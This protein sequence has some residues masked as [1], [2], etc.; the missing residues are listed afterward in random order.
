MSRFR[1]LTGDAI[2][3]LRELPDESVHCVVT[4]PPYWGLRDY[5]AEGQIGLE[6]HPSDWAERLVQVFREVRRVLR[7]D[8]TAWINLGDSY[9]QGGRGALGDSSTL[10][11]GHAH[12]QDES[13]AALT[14]RGEGARRPPRGLKPKDLIGQPWMFAFAAR[15][16]G[17][18][19]RADIV[20]SKSNPLPESIRDRPTKAHEYVFLLSKSAR[21]FY[22]LEAIR[23]PY[24]PAS[25]DRRRYIDRGGHTGDRRG[26]H[27]PGRTPAEREGKFYEANPAGRNRRS[28]WEISTQPFPEAHFAT[29]PEDLVEP[30]VM[31]GSSEAGCCSECGAPLVRVVE[32]GDPDREHQAA[33]GA[34]SSGGYNGK[35]TKNYAAGR[36]QDPSATKARI[37]AGMRERITTGWV[38]SCSCEDASVI[39][40][41][42]LDPFS[43]SGTTGAVALRLG[44]SYIGIELNPKYQEE[45][46]RPR[47]ER[48]AAQ[49][50][51]PFHGTT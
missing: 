14:A 3:K 31:A 4:S 26:E 9:A 42:V 49:G 40:C 17:W 46:A 27:Q 44:R 1:L 45:I 47:L 21:Y 29:F 8:G 12:G 20:W 7:A 33:C 2:A 19:L 6:G 38:P 34:D 48:I 51:L 30:C 5:G 50:L 10:D 18:Y 15:A 16:D 37:L 24:N 43:G 39:P 32:K 28:V 35:A 23:E 36:A 22:D 41:T 11:G 25:L 13:R